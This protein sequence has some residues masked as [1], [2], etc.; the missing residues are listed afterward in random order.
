MIYLI[1]ELHRVNIGKRTG[2]YGIGISKAAS[3]VGRFRI[4]HILM[5]GIWAGAIKQGAA[6]VATTV[7]NAVCRSISDNVVVESKVVEKRL[8]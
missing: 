3:A 1:N 8:C 4:N 6:G 7:S 2:F 5:P